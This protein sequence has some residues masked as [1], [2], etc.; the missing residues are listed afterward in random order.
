MSATM[1]E[2]VEIVAVSGREEEKLL[3]LRYSITLLYMALSVSS[4]A[5]VL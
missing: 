2:S 3:S 1:I 4:Q 5:G